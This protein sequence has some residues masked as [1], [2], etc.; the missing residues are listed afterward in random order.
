[1]S[2][3]QIS[4]DCLVFQPT[5]LFWDPCLWTANDWNAV[6]CCYVTDRYWCKNA[7]MELFWE[8][9]EALLL[10]RKGYLLPT[11]CQLHS[12]SSKTKTNTNTSQRQGQRQRQ[13]KRQRY[14]DSLPTPLLLIKDKV[15]C[16]H[17]DKDTDKHKHK[18]KYKV[19]DNDKDRDIYCKQFAN[20][21]SP[22]HT[23][24]IL[25]STRWKGLKKL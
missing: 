4:H 12:S 23:D 25:S 8:S 10:W 16:K 21:S 9:T 11:V 3:K 22:H 18:D 15:K 1:M 24:S 2:C 17:K 13:R 19:K 5:L 14:T 7:P 6:S 20:S